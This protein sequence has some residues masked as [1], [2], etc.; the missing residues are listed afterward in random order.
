MK[1]TDFQKWLAQSDMLTPSQR[2]RALDALP[3]SNIGQASY[4]LIEE[5][6]ADERKCLIVIYREA[7]DM[8]WRMVFS[9]TGAIIVVA[10]STR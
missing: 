10:L 9:A 1:P 4:N 2:Q 6:I 5:R 8:G 7:R 3:T